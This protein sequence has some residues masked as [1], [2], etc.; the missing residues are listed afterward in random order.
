MNCY[1][2]VQNQSLVLMHIEIRLLLMPCG[3]ENK[4]FSIEI[5]VFE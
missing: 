4:A 2:Q 3:K 5:S 1:F